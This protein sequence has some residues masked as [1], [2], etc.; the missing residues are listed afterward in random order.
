VL[1]R[2]LAPLLVLAALAPLGA[3]PRI[4]RGPS[5]LVY[6]DFW[7]TPLGIHRGTPALF[8]MLAG[9]D[10]EFNDP[11]GVACTRLL[12]Q[13]EDTP[14]ITAFGVNRGAGQIVYNPTMKSLA[15]YGS[16]GSGEG[17]FDH[18]VGI[19]CDP[20]G[21]VLVADTGNHRL[22]KLRY[23]DG[24]LHWEGVLGEP[25]IGP[26]QYHSP[27]GVAL[28][29]QGRIYV[30]DTA[31][32]RVQVLSPEG[33]PL[34]MF[35]GDPNANNS[36]VEPTALA[37][38]DPLEP[39]AAEPEAALYLIDLHHTRIQRFS[40]D[41][42]FLGQVMGKD[43]GRPG[44]VFDSLALDYFNNVWVTDRAE[45]QIHKLDQHLQWVATW[46]HPGQEDGCLDS[47]RGIAIHRHFGQVLVLEQSS[48]QYLWIGADIDQV[49]L[50]PQLDPLHG[51]M[52]R[53]DYH[54]SE[55]AFV[56]AWVET[57]DHERLA[58]LLKHKLQRQG[59]Q[60]LLWNGD[61]DN[62]FRIPNGTYQLVFQAEATYSSA[63]YVKREYR[64]RLAVH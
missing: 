56:D 43:F 27:Q 59:A 32:N 55:R 52:V 2:L 14:Q 60:T 7:H 8:K 54:L 17:H 22:V 30:A 64:R 29:S 9:D 15:V 53:M 24:A 63:T 42:R 23:R 35:G 11:A 21:R 61:Q 10:A 6:P 38:V 58:T 26:G 19:A 28:D 4:E 37:V 3:E 45:G 57:E 47:P 33:W 18:P 41:G 50:A 31:N 48:A 51:M 46:G 34:Y 44:A 1:R 16:P 12:T 20:S 13:G 49:R 39:Y 25:G 36:V 5:S 62:G 40:P